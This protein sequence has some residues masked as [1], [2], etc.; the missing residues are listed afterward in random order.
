MNGSPL[1]D[2][3]GLF[4]SSIVNDIEEI[5]K[6]TVQSKKV[7]FSIANNIIGLELRLA[8][9]TCKLKIMIMIVKG[10][11]VSLALSALL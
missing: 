11:I 7:G 2:C 10:L 1:S 5:N 8:E 9:D 4:S 3:I 6:T